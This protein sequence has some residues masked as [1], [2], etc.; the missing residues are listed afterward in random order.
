HPGIVVADTFQSILLTKGPHAGPGVS[1]DTDPE[2]YGKVKTWLDAE[3]LILQAAKKP[4]TDPFTVKAGPN[5]IDLCAGGGATRACSGGL[6]GVHLTCDAAILAG[7]LE[8]S[9]I[10][11][12]AA[13][14]TDV[15]LLHPQFARVSGT[16]K[17]AK[18][19]LDPTNQFDNTDQTVPGGATTVLSPGS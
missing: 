11:V 15:H 4:S 12:V 5:D 8:L 1:A 9:N 2:F 18:D 10:K 7:M 13:A 14:G 3:A 16:G 19:T 17:D 6:S